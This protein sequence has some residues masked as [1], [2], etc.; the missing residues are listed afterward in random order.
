M[1]IELSMRKTPWY[2][3]SLVPA[4][5]GLL[6][7]RA[8]ELYVSEINRG[9]YPFLPSNAVVE[10]RSIVDARGVHPF[11]LSKPVPDPIAAR[12]AGAQRFESLAARC[13][14]SPSAD[15]VT[16]ALSAM[17]CG[18]PS[19]SFDALTASVLEASR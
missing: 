8:S 1:P 16:D 18:R 4:L 15:S 13:A 14:L 9:Y 7:G 6:G 12:I 10:K 3:Q 19:R 11:P 2:E 17:T 5:I